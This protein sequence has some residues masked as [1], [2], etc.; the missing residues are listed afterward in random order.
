MSGQPAA[1]AFN[2][3]YDA[4]YTGTDVDIF[5]LPVTGVNWC[6]AYMYCKWA[7]RRLCGTIGGGAGAD[8]STL[9]IATGQWSRACGSAANLTYPY[10]NSFVADRCATGDW[11]PVGSSPQCVGA[12][13]GLFDMSGSA[14]EW[15]D[16]CDATGRCR[17][18]G[19]SSMPMTDAPDEADAL[20]CGSSTAVFRSDKFL[21]VG[22]RCC[23]NP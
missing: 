2:T 1:C 5:E 11:E 21:N 19:A 15:V 3:T 13:A 6:D 23:S 7:G 20:K 10:G 16:D 17:V 22:F 18:R 9:S 8:N 4:G 14:A 12:V